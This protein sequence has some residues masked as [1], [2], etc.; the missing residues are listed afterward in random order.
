MKGSSGR[1]GDGF[2]RHVSVVEKR[3]A[4]GAMHEKLTKL[5]GVLFIFGCMIFISGMG[6]KR[7]LGFGL[8]NGRP[9]VGEVPPSTPTYAVSYT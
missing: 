7:M 9:R 5:C 3:W 8:G 4:D 2:G 6:R 1:W